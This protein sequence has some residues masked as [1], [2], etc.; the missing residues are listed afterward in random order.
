MCYYFYYCYYR[1]FLLLPLFSDVR[2]AFRSD[3][4]F[5]VVIIIYIYQNQMVNNSYS[6]YR[7]RRGVVV[8]YC[9]RCTLVALTERLR[10]G[11]ERGRRTRYDSEIDRIGS[12]S[13][14]SYTD[15]E[16]NRHAIIT[17]EC[18]SRGRRNGPNPLPVPGAR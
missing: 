4:G 10:A 13:T 12:T 15:G 16:R 5:L 11:R 7:R 18:I 2:G 8:V 6:D 3:G 1:V 17:R 9:A 14:F